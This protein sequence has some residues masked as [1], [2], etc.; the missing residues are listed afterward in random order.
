MKIIIDDLLFIFAVFLIAIALIIVVGTGQAN[1][2]ENYLVVHATSYHPRVRTFNELNAGI[3]YRG[4]SDKFFVSGG[5]YNNSLNKPS[6]YIGAGSDLVTIKNMRLSLVG[7]VITGYLIPV[8][9]FIIPE[10][11]ANFGDVK[12]IVNYIPQLNIG[13]SIVHEAI[14]FSVGFKF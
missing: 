7:G 5:L 10:V 8:M 1:A 4:Y 6:A 12:F 9:P 2:G 3:A 13:N 14:G 11:S